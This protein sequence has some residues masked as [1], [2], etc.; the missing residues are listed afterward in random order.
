[1]NSTPDNESLGFILLVV[2]MP[3]IAAFHTSLGAPWMI[4]GV[5]TIVVCFLITAYVRRDLIE[6]NL[7]VLSD[8]NITAISEQE[9]TQEHVEKRPEPSSLEV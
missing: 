1:M 8:G 2:A 5:S 3:F 7:D 4:S 9:K 6:E